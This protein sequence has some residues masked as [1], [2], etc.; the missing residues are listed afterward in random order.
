MQDI[1]NFEEWW[2]KQLG[3][4]GYDG[5]FAKCDNDRREGYGRA[6]H[7]ASRCNA[8]SGCAKGNHVD[9]VCPVSQDGDILQG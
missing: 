6:P 8:C 2:Q 7:V 1:D 3:I 9:L 5:V 4:L